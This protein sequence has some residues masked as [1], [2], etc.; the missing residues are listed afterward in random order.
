MCLFGCLTSFVAAL[1]VFPAALSLAAAVRHLAESRSS[2]VCLLCQLM[3][4][5]RQ[6]LP[7]LHRR[8]LVLSRR[9]AVLAALRFPAPLAVRPP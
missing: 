4:I 7:L 6:K 8:T 9:L 2:A 1:S 3:T 5:R